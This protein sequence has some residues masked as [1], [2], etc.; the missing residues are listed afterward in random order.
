M[1]Y[2]EKGADYRSQGT[3]KLKRAFQQEA[4]EDSYA[5][6]AKARD[7]LDAS[8]DAYRRGDYAPSKS[9][10]LTHKPWNPRGE[11]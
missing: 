5:N 10:G 2:P 4:L 9:G 7:R 3:E 6:T 8:R 1:P 11:D